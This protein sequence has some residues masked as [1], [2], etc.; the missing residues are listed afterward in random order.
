MI[1]DIRQRPAWLLGRG[2]EASKETRDP[3]TYAAF[4]GRCTL[5]KKRN[6][7]CQDDGSD[8]KSESIRSES[9]RSESIRSE[10]IKSASIES[11]SIK[12]ASTW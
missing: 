3:E 1:I 11:V 9:I 8:A 12:P 6:R 5:G 7:G 10:S 2:C 4:I